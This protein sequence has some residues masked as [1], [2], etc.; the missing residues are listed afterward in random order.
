MDILLRASR[1]AFRMYSRANKE[2]QKVIAGLWSEYYSQMKERIFKN[3]HLFIE[4]DTPE[5]I[6]K[7][8]V[9]IDAYQFDYRRFLNE[10]IDDPFPL[11]RGIPFPSD[12]ND[13][14]SKS[15]TKLLDRLPRGRR[16]NLAAQAKHAIKWVVY[17]GQLES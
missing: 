14:F 5:V 2:E 15:C 13:Y 1:V 10:K 7:L 8:L 11:R 4:K 12:V 3:S 16:R 17:L 9:F 6:E